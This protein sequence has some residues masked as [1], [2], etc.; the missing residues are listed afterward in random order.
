MTVRLLF[1]KL[2]SNAETRP[3]IEKIRDRL[4][5]CFIAGVEEWLDTPDSVFDEVLTSHDDALYGAYTKV[6]V[7]R[8]AVSPA[9]YEEIRLF[10]G[11]AMRMVDRVKYHVQADYLFAAG[12]P[13][14]DDSFQA[15]SDLVFRH[16]LF[17]DAILRKYKFDAVISQNFSHLGW[18]LPLVHFC[19][20][21]GI[22]H[23]FLHDVGQFP[24]IQYIQESVEDLGK[25][26][27]GASLKTICGPRLT[28][29][30]PNRVVQH[31]PRLRGEGAASD[32][33]H[34]R[35][36]VAQGRSFKT[37]TLSAVLTSGIVRTQVSGLR[38]YVRAISLKLKRFAHQPRRASSGFVK[39]MGRVRMTKKSMREESRNWKPIPDTE[40]FVYFPLHFQPEA[41]TSA[42]GRHFVDQREA[43]AIVAAS[44]PNDW[45]LVVKEHPHQ[46]RR[47]YERAPNYWSR[48][49]MI[50]NVVVIP[51][52]SDNGRLIADCE[53]V[54][55]ISHST[56][57]TEAWA[58]GRRVV[59][60]GYSHLREAPGVACA[61]SIEQLRALWEVPFTP[62]SVAEME[63]Y[64]RRVEESTFEAA[65]YGRPGHLTDAEAEV[66][67]DRTQRNITDLILAWLSTKGLCKYP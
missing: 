37:S 23:L 34:G 60:L 67:I 5:D 58:I 49:A 43:V 41:S 4:G 66:V 53:G 63:K 48:I 31:L 9:L 25:L 47:L 55:S 1:V 64:L 52:D 8:L 7:H 32:P 19:K 33:F 56:V 42:K 39:T 11:Q 30:T 46:W 61:N 65:L 17:W 10:E 13:E 26:G 54:V 29:E 24:G 14:Y 50:P 18:D 59:F 38:G 36:P 15:R 22:P 20:R 62:P 27:L 16:S 45:K 12:M 57:A 40:S 44:L 35:L 51:H 3:I 21:R 2:G 28:S 6:D